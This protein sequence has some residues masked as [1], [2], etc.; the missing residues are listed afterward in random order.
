LQQSDARRALDVFPR[1][2]DLRIRSTCCPYLPQRQVAIARTRRL[3]ARRRA[4]K[5]GAAWRTGAAEVCDRSAR[6]KRGQADSRFAAAGS[7]D[8]PV[9][10]RERVVSDRRRAHDVAMARCSSAVPVLRC[11]PLAGEL[12][13]DASLL[14]SALQAARLCCT[15]PRLPLQHHRDAPRGLRVKVPLGLRADA[16]LDLRGHA[17]VR[18][19]HDVRGFPGHSGS[20]FF[21]CRRYP[22]AEV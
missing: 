1:H 16:S 8:F 10:R 4:K 15:Y 22:L 11:A 18:I 2:R 12:A 13:V 17:R 14:A 20:K 21:R 9:P 7:W 19:W 3:T 5:C 6:S